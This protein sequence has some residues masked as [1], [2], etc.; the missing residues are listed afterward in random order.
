MTGEENDLNTPEKEV[1][2]NLNFLKMKKLILFS[3]LFIC[4]NNLS[5][6][7]KL[8]CSTISKQANAEKSFK[9]VKIKITL[10]SKDGC[11]FVIDGDYNTWKGTFTGTV[12]ASGPNGCPNGT[13]TFGLIIHDNGSTDIFGDKEFT[14]I[15][16]EDKQLL[17]ELI[18][19]IENTY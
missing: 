5:Y 14:S 17:S 19:S 9:R 13:Y 4:L 10:K 8:I 3:S 15:L 18:H 11:K 12:T 2:L 16:K 7:S 1:R 6:G